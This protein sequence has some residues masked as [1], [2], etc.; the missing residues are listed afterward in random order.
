MKSRFRDT[1]DFDHLRLFTFD[2]EYEVD[3]FRTLQLPRD[4]EN[5]ENELTRQYTMNLIEKQKN[6]EVDDTGNI[7]LKNFIH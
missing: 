4:I 5:F 7:D 3:T 6:R 2:M 1:I